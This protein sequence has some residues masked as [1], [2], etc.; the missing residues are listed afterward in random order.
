MVFGFDTDKTTVREYDHYYIK[1]HVSYLNNNPSLLLLI[2][3]H[4]DNRG[5]K[6][7]NEELS[8]QRAREVYTL[9]IFYGASQSQLQLKAHGEMLP[10]SDMSVNNEDV[11]RE[12]RRVDLR[13]ID[14][15]LMSA[16]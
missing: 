4:A 14:N 12:N 11:W 6:S 5:S 16:K 10:V 13:Y 15:T 9:M 7:Y 2:S 8:R 1:Q 3:G